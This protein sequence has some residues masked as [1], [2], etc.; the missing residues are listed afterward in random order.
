MKPFALVAIALLGLAP[1][2]SAQQAADKPT[3]PDKALASGAADDVQD[4]IVLCDA[5]PIF[6]RL[7]V[8]VGGK[9]FREYWRD[10]MLAIFAE[11]DRDGDEVLSKS[12]AVKAPI[13]DGVI[14][15][16]RGVVARRESPLERT[17]DAEG[18]VSRDAFLKAYELS[19]A[20]PFNTRLG[21]GRSRLGNSTLALLD[22]DR[23]GRLS[24]AELRS[25][26]ASLR[27]RDY[28]DD[29]IVSNVEVTPGQSGFAFVAVDAARVAAPPNADQLIHVVRTGSPAADEVTLRLI[30]RYDTNRDG[31]LSVSDEQ[32]AEIH[33][34]A[35]ARKELDRD[36]NGILD[37]GELGQFAM[38][39]PHAE[40]SCDLAPGTGGGLVPADDRRDDAARHGYALRGGSGSPWLVDAGDVQLEIRSIAPAVERAVA[41]PQVDQNRFRL[42]DQDNNGHV[43]AEEARRVGLNDS[44]FA[45][46][47]RDDDGK[48]SRDEVTSYFQR[49]QAAAARRLMLQVTDDGQQLFELLDKDRDGRLSLREM[50]AAAGLIDTVD[51]NRDGSLAGSEIPRRIR[52][53]LTSE[54]AAST[55]AGNVAVFAGGMAPQPTRS[56]PA[57]SGPAW[58]RRMD[59]NHDGDVSPR[60]FLGPRQEFDRL[61]LNHDGLLEANEATG[62]GSR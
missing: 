25:A 40:F 20:G 41:N 50:R 56:L 29:E 23:D 57:S 34:S 62:G 17:G 16:G 10:L 43:D 12:E 42:L 26:E 35:A 8:L 51:A 55:S 58:F 49:Q 61:D 22:S 45:S 13:L 37:R 27:K 36:A 48:V 4:L 6:V 47:D 15:S 38:R 21:N 14:L 30:S 19:P 2:L 59:R 18:R 46:I 5:R 60:E 39:P 9:S 32:S 53:E 11:L 1:T 44:L 54:T 24:A 28:D 3:L 7:H 33:L 52:L 31:S